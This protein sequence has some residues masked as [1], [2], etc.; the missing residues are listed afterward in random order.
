MEICLITILI[1][2]KKKPHNIQDNSAKKTKKKT[3]KETSTEKKWKS[4]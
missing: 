3:K 1:H 4:I 2:T